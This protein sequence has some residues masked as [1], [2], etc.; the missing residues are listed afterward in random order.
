MDL[1]NLK[2][3]TLFFIMNM[4]HW[5]ISEAAP[6]FPQPQRGFIPAS[7][8]D[9]SPQPYDFQYKVDSPPSGTLFG[10]SE[11]GDAQGRV[12]GSYYVLLPD[13]RLMNVEYT[14]DGESGFVPRITFN[15]PNSQGT[16]AATR[17]G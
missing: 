13:G 14:V 11:T 2:I 7:R 4:C 17:L 6:Q 15:P 8:E 9:E 10:Q 3:F 16:P 12:V 1:R 5:H